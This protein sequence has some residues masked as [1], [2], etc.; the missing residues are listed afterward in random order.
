MEFDEGGRGRVDELQTLSLCQLV[1]SRVRLE[2]VE[3]F[4][5]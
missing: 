1:V 4:D 3:E 5:D 2:L